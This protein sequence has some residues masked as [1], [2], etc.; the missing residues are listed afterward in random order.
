MKSWSVLSNRPSA[1]YPDS[2]IS[3]HSPRLFYELVVVLIREKG[4]GACCQ[5]RGVA[6]VCGLGFIMNRAIDRQLSFADSV[7][8]I[9]RGLVVEDLASGLITITKTFFGDAVAPP[10]VDPIDGQAPSD[11]QVAALVNSCYS[12]ERLPGASVHRFPSRGTNMAACSVVGH[13]WGA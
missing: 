9:L 13:A 6:T 2:A 1:D 8:A 11:G 4:F 5:T 7:L 3:R 12:G 10:Q